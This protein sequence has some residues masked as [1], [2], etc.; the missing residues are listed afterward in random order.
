[1]N[2]F[3]K[4]T[5][6]KTHK[7]SLVRRDD[8][9]NVFLICWYSTA[10]HDMD[11]IFARQSKKF[12]IQSLLIYNAILFI[13]L[14]AWLRFILFAWLRYTCILFALLNLESRGIKSIANV[15]CNCPEVQ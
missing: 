13:C 14:F 2:I 12:S 11:Q 7:H 10:F 8:V 15:I 3:K 4:K 1:M 5:K 9:W 6:N